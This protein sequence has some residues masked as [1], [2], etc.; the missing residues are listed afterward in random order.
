MATQV[1]IAHTGQRLQ[2]DTAQ[3]SV[4]DD[5]KSSVARQTSIPANQLI[6]L[7][8]GGKSVK[9]QSLRLETEI[10]VYDRRITQPPSPGTN[11]VSEVPL[12]KQYAVPKAP[13][14][15][16]NVEDVAS[17]QDLCHDR[18]QWALR[19]AN[20]CTDMASTTRDRYGEMDVMTRCLDAAVVNL[21]HS[22]K[23]VEPKYEELKK[24]VG[25]TL[26]ENELLARNWE[27][28]LALARNMPVS[29][30][31]VK[32]MT[33]KDVR[34]KQATLEDLIELET[35]KKAT[36]LASTSERK[37]KVRTED[38]E[39]TAETMYQG[40]EG[41]IRDFEELV[42]RSTISH[43]NDASQLL[44]DI[45]A[46]ARKIDTDAQ[47]VQ[48]YTNTHRDL[49][50]AS[51]TA[52]NH[53]ERLIPS[54][55]K[56]AKEMETILQYATASRNDIAA[57]V[58]Q[59]MRKVT[60]ITSIH[61]N[62]KTL[63]NGLNNSEE[64][65]TTFDY[66]RLIHQL[67]YMYASFVAESI[68]RREWSDK[69]KT[70]S[71]TLANEMALFQD[72]ESKRR[73]K[74]QKVVGSSYGEKLSNNVIGLEVNLLGEEE[75]WPP[76]TKADLEDFLDHL[77]RQKADPEMVDEVVKLVNELN[78]PT[79]QQSKRLKAFKNGSVHEAALGRSGLLIR[80]D[81]DL[82][83]SVQEDKSKLE[84]KLKTAESRV[85][86]LE[87]LLHRSQ[88]PRPTL[89]SLFGHERNDSA[90]SIRST[91]AS[92]ETRRNSGGN[93]LLQQR[94]QQLEAELNTEKE[95]SAAIEKDFGARQLQHND[96]QDRMDE[97]NSTK[98]DL[99][100]NMEALKK[101]F[102][103]ERRSFESEI[104]ILKGKLEQQEE[105]I[106]HFDASRE[107]EKASYDGKVD[108]LAQEV[109]RL[110]KEKQDEALKTQGQ[111]DFLRQEARLQR[112]QVEGLEVKLQ[113]AHD[114]ANDL[115][116]KLE[117]VESSADA[118]LGALR[119]IHEHLSPGARLP[120]DAADML[121]ALVSRT[122]DI[123][124]QL[125]TTE[126]DMSVLNADLDEA[127][128]TIKTLR[129]ELDE[130]K[131]G[132]ARQEETAMHLRENLS[133]EKARVVALESEA[134]DGRGQLSELRSRLADGETGSES[135]RKKLEEEEQRITSL[136]EE[137]AS[138]QS[139]VGSLEEELRMYK[140][141]LQGSQGKVA[142]LT[143]RF[144]A[145]TERTKDLTQRLYS[146]N[147]RICRLLE[148]LGFSVTRDGSTMSI[149]KVPRAE[150]GS[151][152][153]TQANDSSDPGQASIRR[154]ATFAS[155]NLADSAD[156]ELLHWMSNTDLAVEEDRYEAFMNKLG[157]FDVDLFGETMYRRVKD[158]EHLARKLQRDARAYRDKARGLQKDAH[159]KIAY[160]HFK[161]GDLAL[162]LPTRNQSA[163]A[164]AAFNVGFPHYFLREQDGH[165][166]R[167]REW[168]VA[169]ITHI[170]ERVVDLSRGVRQVPNSTAEA[171]DDNPFQLSDGLRWY[172]IDAHEDKAGAPSTPGLGKS[173][174][175]ATN[176]EARA[177][178]HA[179]AQPAD[180]NKQRVVAQ[181]IEGVSK[182]L[183][184]SLE[185]RRS[186]SNSKK[187][188]PFAGGAALLKGTALASE[189]NSLRA[190][191]P[192]SPT[193]SPPA[194]APATT[195]APAAVPASPA[196]EG[197]ADSNTEVRKDIDSL[198][199]AC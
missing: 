135:L 46:V 72:E 164:W 192:E 88:A 84:N 22:V 125:K 96:I 139:Q 49:A 100:A 149:Q 56:R 78:T 76:V 128:G 107:N 23:Q 136:V 44:E 130:A 143:H 160:R 31:M 57:Q 177:D 48:E 180:R 13:D 129:T 153:L 117:T 198:M 7:T 43:S 178:M 194:P 101:E 39:K 182:A 190:A 70:D 186:S 199:G 140:E 3:F 98:K 86:R 68:R 8:T 174:T 184:K 73:K 141:K 109:E 10:L 92:D 82:L 142:E 53:T 132:L 193:G 28:Y 183:S 66:L 99:L 111:V 21:E 119:D 144:D 5:F 133:E 38:L 114:E 79:K 112:E 157:N 126:N 71:S 24:W 60:E 191:A 188:V 169:R 59:F 89:G 62:V 154:S 15:I 185:S 168:L 30:A 36:S 29:P 58:V 47:I 116:K 150:R 120:E 94:I 37:F 152:S 80:G 14:Y 145:R 55:K 87:D 167:S 83:R 103:G 27:G 32:F 65:L 108:E 91:A 42:A 163:G 156:L 18:R 4:L 97:V 9:I 122:A 52:Q 134:T 110:Q 131:E 106:D 40:I 123:V 25:P 196:V 197:G 90:N 148:R 77:Q 11:P 74:W 63:I 34:K 127:N 166:L 175:A 147:D 85:R 162:F 2:I 93:D 151:L 81:D 35:V 51:K 118:R 179:H 1:L 54:L 17:W 172:M 33:S 20:D 6:A 189:T 115:R 173:T 69:I 75:A 158:V 26:E 171:E 102:D 165:R 45:E 181:S 187:A 124:S 146:Q 61:S 19:I 105:D 95:R 16:E 176:V 64:D 138:R 104:R 113:A 161:E 12:P 50:Q 195:A 67:P 121:D 137:L 155:R 41:L 159:E 170:E